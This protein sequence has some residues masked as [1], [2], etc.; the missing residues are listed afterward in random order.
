MKNYYLKKHDDKMNKI[1]PNFYIWGDGEPQANWSSYI[2]RLICD[3]EIGIDGKME[4]CRMFAFADSI[5][6]QCVLEKDFQ[7]AR[8]ATWKEVRDAVERERKGFF[9]LFDYF[10][11]ETDE[12]QKQTQKQ[13]Y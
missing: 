4:K 9:G 8:P 3:S 12:D 7:R 10:L 1:A 13:I 11:G 2:G 5:C 6:V